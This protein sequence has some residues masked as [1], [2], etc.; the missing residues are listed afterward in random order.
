MRSKDLRN[1]RKAFL[2]LQ[3]SFDEVLKSNSKP[4]T[5]KAARKKVSVKN[6]DFE[7]L[8]DEEDVDDYGDDPKPRTTHASL[9]VLWLSL[10]ILP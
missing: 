10:E 2:N 8:G 7:D 4:R 5:G 1:L 9:T 6:E 3:G